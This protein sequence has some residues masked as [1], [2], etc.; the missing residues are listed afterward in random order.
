M[1]GTKVPSNAQ[2]SVTSSW[3]NP[4]PMDKWGHVEY[5]RH[6]V[7][8]FSSALYVGFGELAWNPDTHINGT[9]R[10]NMHVEY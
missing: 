4:E 6:I 10:E 2:P 7:D 3:R 1:S 8:L 9:K 5:G